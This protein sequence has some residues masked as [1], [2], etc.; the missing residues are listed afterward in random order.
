MC[1]FLI[2]VHSKAIVTLEAGLVKVIGGRFDKKISKNCYLGKNRYK[3]LYLVF[4]N[5]WNGRS[6]EI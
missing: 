1:Y 5:K 3:P 6:G 4:G 2:I